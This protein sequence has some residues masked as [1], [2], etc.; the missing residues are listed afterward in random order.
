VSTRVRIEALSEERRAQ[1]LD[2]MRRSVS[3][4]R[5][6]VTPPTTDP[7][8]NRLLERQA[9]GELAGFLLVRRSDDEIVGMCNLSQIFRG[10]LKSAYV[11]FGAVK[12]FAGQGYMREGVGLVVSRAFGPMGLHRLEANIQPG[13][14]RSIRLVKSL[15]FTKEGFS[16]RYLKIG[17]RWRDHERWAILAENWR[18]V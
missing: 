12:G 18:R 6:W 11:G 2:A 10:N 16:E 14:S 5:P 3:F 7:D 4:Q 8:Y 9:A 17:G 13:N 15:G 1:A